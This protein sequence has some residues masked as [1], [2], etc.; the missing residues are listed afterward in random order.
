MIDHGQWTSVPGQPPWL[1]TR[2]KQKHIPT[3]ADTTAKDQ[4]NN[5][6]HVSSDNEQPALKKLTL[7]DGSVVY[8]EFPSLE[9]LFEKL[10]RFIN[11]NS[12]EK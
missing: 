3:T 9:N 2:H 1:I 12:G 8:S 7:P 10:Q 4:K 6:F 11:G 5:P